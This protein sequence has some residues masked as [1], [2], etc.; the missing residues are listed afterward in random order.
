[1]FDDVAEEAASFESYEFWQ[2]RKGISITFGVG[3]GFNFANSV[4]LLNLDEQGLWKTG[5]TDM[6]LE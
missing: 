3:G 2:K 6:T 5:S 4:V 1:M